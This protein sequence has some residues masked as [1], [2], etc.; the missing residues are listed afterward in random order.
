MNVPPSNPGYN[1]T[2]ADLSRAA[3]LSRDAVN[4]I[5]ANGRE[6]PDALAILAAILRTQAKN[7]V[8][9]RPNTYQFGTYRKQMI[10][11]DNPD[12]QYLMIQNTGNGDLMVIFE[13][14]PVNVVD[15]SG[16][17][18]AQNELVG[19]QT[20]AL[21]IIGGGYFEPLVA[22]RNPITI[23]TLNGATNGLVIEGA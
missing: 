6:E 11:A 19:L 17:A 3:V 23:F 22:P 8:S 9:Y 4:R 2:T 5:I 15:N 20:R 21:R 18:D 12:R 14:G 13:D 10:L 1:F 7:S 16:S